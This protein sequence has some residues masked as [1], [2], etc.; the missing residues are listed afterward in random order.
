MCRIDPARRPI[1]AL[2]LAGLA[3]ACWAQAP[4]PEAPV[5]AVAAYLESLGLRGLLA[6]HLRERLTGATREEAILIAERLGRVY[7]E[8]IEAATDPAERQRLEALGQELLETVPEAASFD[9]RLTLWRARYVSAERVCERERLRLADAEEVAATLAALEALSAEFADAARE[10][11]QRVTNLERAESRSEAPADGFRALRDLLAEARRHRSLASYYLGWTD[12]YRGMLTGRRDLATAAEVSLGYV[13][14]AEGGRPTIDRIPGTSLRYEHVA[15]AVIGVALCRSLAGEHGDAIAWLEEASEAEGLAPEVAAQLRARRIAVLGA[16][17][18][19]DRLASDMGD[20]EAAPL[21]LAE[22]RLLVVMLL[23]RREAARVTARDAEAAERLLT[24]SLRRMID[25]G[26]IGHIIELVDRYGTLPLGDDGFVVQY[27]RAVRL[28]ESARRAHE[29]HAAAN[30]GANPSAEE[31]TADAEAR[32]LYR[33]AEEAMRVATVADDAGEFPAER[34]RAALLRGLAM[35]YAGEPRAAGEW[36]VAS[37]ADAAPSTRAE[38]LWLAIVAFDHAASLGDAAASADVRRLG[39][40]FVKAFPTDPRAAAVL[41]RQENLEG[42]DQG[43]ALRILLDVPEDDPR[44]EAAQRRATQLLYRQYRAAPPSTRA[45]QAAAFLAVASKVLALDVA[46]AQ[47]QGQSPEAAER[48]IG[49]IRQMLD[50]ALAP[51]APDPQAVRTLFDTLESILAAAEAGGTEPRSRLAG[52]L[53]FRRLQLAI[54]ERDAQAREALLTQLDAL[55]GPFADA[56]H[57][58]LYNAALQ[59]LAAAVTAAPPPGGDEGEALPADPDPDADRAVIRHGSRL[60]AA[61]GAPTDAIRAAGIA[62]IAEAVARSA[63]RRA[64]IDGDPASADIARRLDRLR[65][66]AGLAS[67]PCLRRFAVMSEAAGD[68]P[69]ATLA[70]RTL[71]AGL[72]P[73]AP[74]WFEARHELFRTLALSDEAAARAALAQHVA[75]YGVD[76]PPPWDTRFAALAQTLGVPATPGANP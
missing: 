8:E 3:A 28:Y 60:I 49:L 75:L 66:D 43:V 40:E 63:E 12:Y 15:R 38:A 44:H 24:A 36:L 37:T 1:A 56:A 46:Q 29:A 51:A 39:G 71:A 53:A 13:L 17:G 30:P 32:S 2:A 34:G 65:L 7:A 68:V 64:T 67:E 61:A 9:L 69:A 5:D 41:A 57:R 14:N 54:V 18:R 70:W 31:P 48:A 25:M 4:T 62:A 74:A 26:R 72:D 55:G 19:W 58:F 10:A 23:E 6:A 47:A 27:V 52:E 11:A 45:E 33:Q 21:S 20:L 22:A 50:A 35:F 76:A 59:T 73:P 42:I 16:A